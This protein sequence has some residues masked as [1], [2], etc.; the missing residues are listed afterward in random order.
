MSVLLE[1]FKNTK[2]ELK[3]IINVVNTQFEEI[4]EETNIGIHIYI[5]YF[6]F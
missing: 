4:E 5:T 2:R 3:R 6:N 1:D